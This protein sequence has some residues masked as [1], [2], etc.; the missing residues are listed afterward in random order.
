MAFD[1]K[2]IRDDVGRHCPHLVC[3]DTESGLDVVGGLQITA[4]TGREIT[5]FAIRII[6]PEEF[7]RKPITVF[8]TANRIPRSPDRHVNPDGSC[9]IG[10]PAALHARMGSGYTVS[11]YVLGPVTDYFVGQACVESGL[12]WPA[13]EARHG[14]TGILDFWKQ[15]LRCQDYDSALVLLIAAARTR[16]PRK[17]SR[18]PCGARRRIRACHRQEIDWV[19]KRFPYDF[20]SDE[21]ETI[22]NLLKNPR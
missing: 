22:R 20:L 10:V 17:N 1:R 4:G 8:E 21:I 3:V 6:V 2:R 14:V 19:R 9:C 12:P 7:P 11:Q 16:R 13:G 18:C 15:K 5:R